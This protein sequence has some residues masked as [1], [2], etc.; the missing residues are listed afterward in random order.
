[1]LRAGL[2]I[3][4]SSDGQVE[5]FGLASQETALRRRAQERGY[6]IVPDGTNEVFRDDG[7]SGGDL[8]RPALARLRGAVRDSRVDVLLCYDPDRLSRSLSDL[9][10]VADEMEAAG[11]RLEFLTQ[12]TDQSP[13]GRMFFAI[14]GAVAEYE[15]S[16]I[17]ERTARGL[18]E[19][20]RQ[21]KVVNPHNLPYG[22]GFNSGTQQ[23]V[24]D[25]ERAQV[26]R[27]VFRLFVDEGLPLRQVGLRLNAL[28]IP[29]PTG[30]S[31]WGAE[32]LRGWL[33][34]PAYK[35]DYVQ[36][37]TER[38]EPLRRGGAG[39]RRRTVKRMKAPDT[40]QHVSVPA[41]V[42]PAV[43]EAAQ[44]RLVRNQEL[45][46]RNTRRPYLLQGL[47]RCGCGR[48]LSGWHGPHGSYRCNRASPGRA[49]VQGRSCT[50]KPVPQQLI[51][52][53]VWEAVSG[54]LRKPDTLVAELQRRQEENSPARE[55][56]EYERKAYRQRLVEIPAEQAR[57]VE[58]YGKGLI[59][60]ELI[61]P[62][63]EQLR[64]EAATA[65]AKTAEI[66]RRLRGLEVSG[67]EEA[68]VR[69]FAE[70]MGRGLSALDFAG[71]QEVLRL[72]V[73]D[74]TINDAEAVVRTIIPIEHATTPEDTMQL[75]PAPPG[76]LRPLHP[77]VRPP[78]TELVPYPPISF[79]RKLWVSTSLGSSSSW[80]VRG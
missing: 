73:E 70:R 63:L 62:R 80:L 20:A 16:K 18:V 67:S 6:L 79:L 44:V 3:R 11:V 47:L 76:W 25:T 33:R 31:N 19:K 40:W 9:L 35:G 75:C 58:G 12:D 10:L 37:R 45:A 39:A 68:A 50:G 28:G 74:V 36:L 26:V 2:Y 4:V 49:D 71:R 53:G 5:K 30:G 1:M 48:R 69:S 77:H 51:E 46:K 13:E 57:L 59:P 54:L 55:A 60:E 61:R 7:Y 42:D 66:G 65:E 38:V 64:E 24:V 34:H 72:L 23:V 32:T 29:T 8:Q 17:R 15:K 78:N 27:L 14:R 56:L 22:F 41:V 52:A 21:G 43:W